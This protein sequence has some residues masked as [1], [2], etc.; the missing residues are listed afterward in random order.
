MSHDSVITPVEKNWSACS[1]TEQG[2]YGMPSAD[3][4]APSMTV[5]LPS[6]LRSS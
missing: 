2:K 1:K 3:T 5:L 6:C 4:A